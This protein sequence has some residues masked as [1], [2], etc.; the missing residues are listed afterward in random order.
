[1]SIIILCSYISL[2]CFFSI[3]YLLVYLFG[4]L[5]IYFQP[6]ASNPG[7]VR[8]SFGGVGRNIAGENFGCKS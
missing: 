5:F 2:A 6:E 3:L 8:M 4:C 1:M 7:K